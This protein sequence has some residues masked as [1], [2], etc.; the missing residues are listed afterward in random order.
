MPA[1]EVLQTCP[2]WRNALLYTSGA[3]DSCGSKVI[4]FDVTDVKPHF[5]Y[6]VAFK[7]HVGY[8]K[9]TIK[10]TIVDEG[11]ATCVK[12]LV[13]WK[14]LSSPTLSQSLTMLISFDSHSFHPHGILPSFPVQLGG[15][16]V[17]VDFEV[18]DTT[19]DYNLLLGCNWNYAMNAFISFIF[20]TLC[21]PH[22][23]KIVTID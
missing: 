23:G 1:L 3:L 5:N 14:S 10:H 18:V 2:S 20:C 21:F 16:I 17:E 22:D 15:K 8:S 12:S 7:I 4:K 9:Y 13:S 11:A 19:L 6:H